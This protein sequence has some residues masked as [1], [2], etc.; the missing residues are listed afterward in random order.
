MTDPREAHATALSQLTALDWIGVTLVVFP[1]LFCMQ[2]PFVLA[3]IFAGLLA[4]M[5][6]P[7]PPL[8]TL[9]L[10]P[11]LAPT[12]AVVPLLVLA[13]GL[14]MRLSIGR[15]RLLIVVAFVVGASIAGL[16]LA[17]LYAPIFS[18]AGRITPA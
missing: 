6:G 10:Q 4:D 1:C 16:C 14:L 2:F 15:R 8:T 7:V 13:A 5:G 3:P 17:G 12:L 18:L 9:V 11:W